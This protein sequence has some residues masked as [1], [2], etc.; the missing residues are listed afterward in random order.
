MKDKLVVRVTAESVYKKKMLMK[1]VMVVIAILLLFSSAVYG[2]VYIVNQTGNFTINLDPNLKASYKIMM[3]PY[4]DFRETNIIL[5]AEAL[6]YMDNITESWLPTNL[7]KLEG[8]HSNDNHI[9]YTFFLRNEG[10][11]TI[12]YMASININSV[13]K[14]VDEAV[15]VAVYYN[16]SK[17]LYAKFQKGTKKS[18][19]NTIPF[20]SN[21]KVMEKIRKKFEPNDVDK[22]TVVIWLEGND[23]ECIDDILGGEM[24]MAMVIRKYN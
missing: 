14:N 7:D 3:S 10:E 19:P 13:I 15:R 8:E 9:A 2:I 12:D 1:L 11:D 20:V 17:T 6:S 24:K 22:Y 21:I 16:G 18:E 4:S 5:E 23:P